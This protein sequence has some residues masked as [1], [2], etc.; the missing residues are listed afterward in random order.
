MDYSVPFL[1]VAGF[2][3]V[4]GF[5]LATDKIAT[6]EVSTAVHLVKM[7]PVLKWKSFQGQVHN[8][9]APL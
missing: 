2:W 9:A 3:F 4:L 6:E 1:L 7:P 8:I 5:F